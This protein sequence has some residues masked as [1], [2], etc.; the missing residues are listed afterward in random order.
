[1]ANRN[2]VAEIMECEYPDVMVLWDTN[3]EN[4]F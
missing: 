3:L 2:A 1:M 4:K